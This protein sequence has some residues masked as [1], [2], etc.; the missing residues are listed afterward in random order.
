MRDK[1][2]VLYIIG[3]QRGGSTIVGRVLG[4]LPGFEF[5]GEVRRLWEHG[6]A[7]GRTCGCGL[8]LRDCPVW[9][10]VLDAVSAAGI[11]PEEV[12]D[13][14]HQVAPVRHSWRC[15]GGLL[16][17]KD[18]PTGPQATYTQAMGHVYAALADTYDADVLVDSSKLPA[19]AAVL[20]GIPGVDAYYLHLVRDPRGVLASQLRRHHPTSPFHRLSGAVAGVASWALRHDT[21]RRLE[22]GIGDVRI[23]RVRYEDFVADA[24]AAAAAIGA[25][26]GHTATPLAAGPADLPL[27]HT[28][29]G[30]L[31]SRTV[32]LREDI[33]WRTEL[34]A[35][36]RGVV[37]TLAAPWL[38][39]YGYLARNSVTNAP[40][41][42]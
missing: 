8:L 5:A 22:S 28:P 36:E 29:A 14:Q 21:P 26:V 6:I 18:R 41:C 37:T 11:D 34:S 2:K 25:F 33:R 4:L 15:T 23:L 42:A 13:L 39:R 24:P 16:D 9:S 27:V 19:D 7:P 10:T 1:V 32:E 38:V 17:R 40:R 30:P 31:P 3:T 12:P 35:V 20:A